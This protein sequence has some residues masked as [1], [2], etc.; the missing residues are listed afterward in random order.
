MSYNNAKNNLMTS[1]WNITGGWS[2][3]LDQK[4]WFTHSFHG[5][6]VLYR[7]ERVDCQ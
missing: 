5:R 1:L 6:T 3:R 7:A 2:K 4:R